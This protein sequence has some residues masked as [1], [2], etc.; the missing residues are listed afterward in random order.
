ML[1]QSGEGIRCDRCGV[2]HTNDFTYYSYDVRDVLVQNNYMPQLRYNTPPVFSFDICEGCMTEIG[3]LVKKNH[4]ATKMLDHRK[5]PQGIY[6]DLSQEHLNG[7]FT[8]HHTCITKVNVLMS[9]KAPTCD[10]CS[11]PAPTLTPDSE[12]PCSKCGGTKFSRTADTVT[13]DKYLELWVSEAV[14]E[15]FKK[16]SENLRLNPEAA[17]WST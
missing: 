9:G 4:K 8:F 3:E 2:S 7:T 14:Y 15:D 16:R 17:K 13:D 5:C 12:E 1:L 11:T 10:G 6:C